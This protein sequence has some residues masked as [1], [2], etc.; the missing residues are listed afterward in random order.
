[1]CSIGSDMLMQF[2]SIQSK[3]WSKSVPPNARTLEGAK[4]T[5]AT[6]CNGCQDTK[7]S[8]CQDATFKMRG[9]LDCLGSFGP[10]VKCPGQLALI[11]HA[12]VFV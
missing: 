7:I 8:R 3:W 9:N 2:G 11:F 6:L 12:F 1:M 5:N 4:V 10:S